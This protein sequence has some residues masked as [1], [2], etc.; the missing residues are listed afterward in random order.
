M[1]LKKNQLRHVSA[2][3]NGYVIDHIP[4]GQGLRILA[5]L[6]LAAYTKVITVGLNLPSKRLGKKDIIK[7]ED[8]SISAQEKSRIALLAPGATLV[9]IKKYHVVEKTTLETPSEIT[10]LLLC[11]NQNCIT[12]CESIDTQFRVHHAGTQLRVQCAYCERIF[13]QQDISD[14]AQ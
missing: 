3:N 6:H 2:I 10:G 13:F 11:P 4:S 14:L 5:L 1:P 12:N 8:R 9:R 7:L